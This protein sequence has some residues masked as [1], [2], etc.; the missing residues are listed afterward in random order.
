MQRAFIETKYK[1]E[2]RLPKDL[3]EKL[4]KKVMLSTTIQFI[5]Q[6]PEI[7][8]RLSAYHKEVFLFQSIHGRIP[9]QMLG[10]DNVKV[11][12]EVDCFLYIGDGMF[13]PTALL[14]NEKPV[15]FY[16]PLSEKYDFLG[17]KDWEKSRLR[18]KV[19]MMKYLSAKRIGVLISVKEGQNKVQ[20]IWEKVKEK[21][22]GDDKQFFLFVGNEIRDLENFNFIDCWVNTACPRIADDFEKMVNLR[23]LL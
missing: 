6:L 16:N 18:K 1:G 14:V 7:R 4:P 17:K 3:I 23:D 15:F 22:G 13:H 20:G 21:L 2:I 10:C 9:G 19:A 11:R 12:Q 5:D 8:A